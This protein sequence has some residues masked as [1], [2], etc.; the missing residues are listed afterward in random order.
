MRTST[1][2]LPWLWEIHGIPACEEVRCCRFRAAYQWFYQPSPVASVGSTGTDVHRA[3]AFAL[4]AWH[5]PGQLAS[6]V[7]VQQRQ[8]NYQ[9]SQDSKQPRVNV[10]VIISVAYVRRHVAC[11][12]SESCGWLSLSTDLRSD[13]I[14][15]HH[16][17]GRGCH[18][19]GHAHAWSRGHT[20]HRGRALSSDHRLWHLHTEHLST[21]TD[22]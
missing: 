17:T 3:F 2:S 19:C 9:T 21:W 18:A 10:E 22:R 6:T 14:T 8:W 11:C 12:T 7:L 20:S 13:A 4:V 5:W 1:I 15:A 16:L